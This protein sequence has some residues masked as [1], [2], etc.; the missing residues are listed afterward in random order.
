M[1]TD[2]CRRR[3]PTTGPTPPGQRL[4]IL[5]LAPRVSVSEASFVLRISL[6]TPFSHFLPFLVLLVVIISLLLLLSTAIVAFNRLPGDPT[7]DDVPLI[8][9]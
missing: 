8:V 4:E 9:F 6:F 7:S 2:R 1:I 3:T 5:L